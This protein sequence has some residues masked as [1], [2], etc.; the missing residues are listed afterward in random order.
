MTYSLGADGSVRQHGEASEDHGLT[1]GP[2]FDF[3]YRKA[4][5]P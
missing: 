5:T 1:W 2:S 3:T 4:K